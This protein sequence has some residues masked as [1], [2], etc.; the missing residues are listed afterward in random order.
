MKVWKM[1]QGSGVWLSPL[2]TSVCFPAS[3][4]NGIPGCALM[5]LPRIASE[6]N[7]PF[8]QPQEQ[9]GQEQDMR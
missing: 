5:D 6:G 2:L 7:A 8:F 1:S 4:K 9:L 3:R